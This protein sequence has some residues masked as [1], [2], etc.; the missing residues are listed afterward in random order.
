MPPLHA[1]LST[2]AGAR[3]V[4]LLLERGAHSEQ[5]DGLGRTALH[6]QARW[7]WLSMPSAESRMAAESR[8][9]QVLGDRSEPLKDELDLAWL[10]VLAAARDLAGRAAEAS[11]ALTESFKAL[12]EPPAETPDPLDPDAPDSAAEGRRT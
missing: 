1:A 6:K 9:D 12:S 4:P 7:I 11:G 5:R 3:L 2:P 8:M 10:S